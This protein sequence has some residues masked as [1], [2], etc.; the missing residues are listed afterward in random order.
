MGKILYF[1]DLTRKLRAKNKLEDLADDDDLPDPM[2]DPDYVHVLTD[3]Q[4]DELHYQQQKYGSR[5]VRHPCSKNVVT[6]LCNLRLGTGRMRQK[7]IRYGAQLVTY[8][9]S[10]PYAWMN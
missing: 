7:R 8:Q 10:H 9:S 1:K 5:V 6:D 4:Q 3:R 2:Y